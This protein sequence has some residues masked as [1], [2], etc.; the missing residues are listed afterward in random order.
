VELMA[1][2]TPM[3]ARETLAQWWQ[4]RSR[5][6]R[7]ALAAVGAVAALALIWLIVWQPLMRDSDRLARRVAVDRAALADARRASDEIAGLAR[8]A[9][10]PVAADPRAALDPVLSAQNLKTAATAIERIDDD[11]VRVTFD[12]IGFDAL[13]AFLDAL[14]RDARLRAVEVV[15]TARVEA[16][17]VRADVT[18]TR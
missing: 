18:L 6:E 3:N 1:A 9:A 14:Q 11:R 10:A 7:R 4:L 13:A 5:S 15:A 17:R 2:R 8:T 12:T 16:G